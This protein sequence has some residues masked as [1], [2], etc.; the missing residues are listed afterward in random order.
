[1]VGIAD[2]T[3]KRWSRAQKRKYL[4]KTRVGLGNLQQ[5][6]AM[7]TPRNEIEE[8]LRSLAIENHIVF[9]R[10][11]ENMLV[12]VRVLHQSMDAPRHLHRE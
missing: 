6:P 9:Y 10:I 7:G 2:Y 11:L 8:G 5:M 1:L 12:V 3:Q 4:N